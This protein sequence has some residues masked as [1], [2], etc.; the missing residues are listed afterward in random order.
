MR[1]PIACCGRCYPTARTIRSPVWPLRAVP[2]GAVS[3]CFLH[4]LLIMFEG[5]TRNLKDALSFIE[6]S[7]L[8]ESNIREGLEQVRQ[9]LLEADVNFEVA[10]DFIQRVTE[11]AVGDQVLKSIRP[12][13]QIVGIVHQ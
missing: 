12:S 3:L 5:I 1:S 8:S 4:G 2:Q 7:R 9:A 6:R 13:E 10:G 11:Q